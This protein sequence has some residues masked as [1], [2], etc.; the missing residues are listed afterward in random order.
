MMRLTTCL[1][2]LAGGLFALPA[3]AQQRRSPTEVVVVN[4]RQ[5][6][7]AEFVLSDAGGQR[8]GAIRAPLAGGKRV[9]IKLAKGAPCV[10]T[11][12]ATFDDEFENN[13]A[14]V[15]ACKDKTIRFSN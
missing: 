13:G 9:T 5:A 3:E 6:S 2:V 8:V 14:Q 12:S 4:N 11:V 7:L 10:L 15:D 1:A